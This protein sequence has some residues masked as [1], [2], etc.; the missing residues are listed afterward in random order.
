MTPIHQKVAAKVLHDNGYVDRKIEEI[1]GIDHVT[2]W[3]ASQQATPEE[4]KQFETDFNIWIKEKKQM[5]MVAVQKRLLELIPKEKRIDQVVKAGEFF[6]GKSQTL[7]QQ[8]MTL[9]I[10]QDDQETKSVAV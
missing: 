6:E 3:R 5:G 10:Q 8:N 1:L 7:I 4:L 9:E 2:A